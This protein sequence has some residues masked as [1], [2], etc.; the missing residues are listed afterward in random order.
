MQIR[1]SFYALGSGLIQP[2]DVWRCVTSAKCRS[3][4]LAVELY[5][6]L[7]VSVTQ[8]RHLILYNPSKHPFLRTQSHL[9]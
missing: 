6:R 1:L 5:G 2:I 8:V 3:L 9:M 7:E 4:R